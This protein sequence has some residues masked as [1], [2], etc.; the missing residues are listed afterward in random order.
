MSV[1]RAVRASV[2]GDGV[3]QWLPVVLRAVAA[4][5]LLPAA[6]IKFVYYSQR[7]ARFA[8]LGVPAA[9][10]MVVFVGVVELVTAL[11]L[12]FGVLSRVAALGVVVVMLV[13]I[14]FVGV[15]PSNAVVLL[16]A[17]GVVALGPGKYAA[18]RPESDLFGQFR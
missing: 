16:A 5:V 7:A 13:A 8:E 11:A 1:G 15:V 3:T 12:V 4:T 9:D 17:L 18:W 6:L 10:V 14:S 2:T